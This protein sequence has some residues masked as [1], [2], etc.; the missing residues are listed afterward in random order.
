MKRQTSSNR[1]FICS[2][3]VE[4]TLQGLSPIQTIMKM[5]EPRNIRAM[6][7]RP[8]DVISFGGGWCNHKAPDRLQR[9]YIDIVSDEQ[10]FHQRIKNLLTQQRLSFFESFPHTQRMHLFH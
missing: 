9:I 4:E 5:A 1:P 2:N 3:L 6:G 8:E 7:L 10:I